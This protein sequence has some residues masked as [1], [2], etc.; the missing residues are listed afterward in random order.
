M[1][2]LL[3]IPLA[4][5]AAA[6]PAAG[7]PPAAAPASRTIPSAGELG[8]TILLGKKL[9]EET[10]T[11][12]L[13]APYARNALACASCH[14]DAG[15]HPTAGS[16]V[17]AATAYPAWAPREK[18]VVTL[19]DRVLNCFM[20]S[21][22]GI[23]PPNGSRPSIA[24]TAYVTWLSSGEPIRQNDQAPLGPRALRKIAPDPATVNVAAG[25]ALYLRGCASCH[26]EDGQGAPPVWG[27]RSYNAGAGLADV[28]RLAGYLKVAMPP[29][30][31]VLVDAEAVDVAAYVNSQPRPD[32]VLADHL[33][34]TGAGVYNATV[35]EDVVRAPT[36]PPRSAGRTIGSR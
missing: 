24:L 18:T 32:F 23:R 7:S 6:N 17:G 11:H 13:T 4:L 29:N 34:R 36:W 14:R 19:E 15:A 27:P 28:S 3:W 30:G 31:P 10:S 25:K 35:L 20:R 12:P 26:G 33:P 2:T 22:D 16:L 21:H 8:E 9:F 1:S 5:A